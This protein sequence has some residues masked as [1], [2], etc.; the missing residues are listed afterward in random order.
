MRRG[1]ASVRARAIDPPPHW[2]GFIGAAKTFR[3]K[4]LGAGVRFVE[5]HVPAA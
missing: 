4:N 2:G 3:R 5:S 1:A